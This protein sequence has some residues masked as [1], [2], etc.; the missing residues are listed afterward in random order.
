MT[1]AARWIIVVT[2]IMGTSFFFATAMP[3]DRTI[4]RI[5]CTRWVISS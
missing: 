2:V 4:R 3:T 1:R 5:N